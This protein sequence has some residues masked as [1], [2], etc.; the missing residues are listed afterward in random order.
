MSVGPWVTPGRCVECGA[1]VGDKHNRSCIHSVELVIDQCKTCGCLN[2]HHYTHCSNQNAVFTGRPTVEVVYTA[3]PQYDDPK[4]RA[5]MDLYPDLLS[6]L[7]AADYT[8]LGNKGVV[9]DLKVLNTIVLG[10]EALEAPLI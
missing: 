4:V 6:K 10:L 8:G 5:L 7:K 1:V 3:R 2:G 9:I